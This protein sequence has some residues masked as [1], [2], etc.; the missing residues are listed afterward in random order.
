MKN[1]LLYQLALTLVSNIGDVQA[2][3]LVQHFGNA[4]SI[5][6]ASKSQLEKIE[7]IGSVRAKSIKDFADYAMA[8]KEILFLEKFNINPLFLTD[9]AYPKRLLHCYDSPTLLFYKGTA[10]LNTS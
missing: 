5:F 1:D 8:E 6:S 7:G 2:K 10:D 4:Q 3:I 9:A